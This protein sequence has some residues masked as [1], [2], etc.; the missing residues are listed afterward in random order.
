MQESQV[1]VV[2]TW[3]QQQ[4]QQLFDVEVLTAGSKGMNKS[5][6]TEMTT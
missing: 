3:Q 2:L 4:Q 5:P 6:K 1:Q